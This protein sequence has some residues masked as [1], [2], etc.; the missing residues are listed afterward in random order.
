MP[1]PRGEHH[2]TYVAAHPRRQRELAQLA[3]LAHELQY[4]TGIWVEF[5]E[6][7]HLRR[8]DELLDQVF[9]LHS[10][11]GSQGWQWSRTLADATLRG[12]AMLV[13][14]LLAHEPVTTDDVPGIILDEVPGVD[15][16][17]V[18]EVVARHRIGRLGNALGAMLST[19]GDT[20]LRRL[21]WQ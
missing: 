8:I 11:F 20:A 15:A 18:L 4:E 2:L 12:P 13:K 5:P 7:R 1:D 6:E 19:A 21:N 10:L 16:D 3:R 14:K 17:E 9:G